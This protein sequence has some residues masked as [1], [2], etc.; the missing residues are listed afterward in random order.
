MGKIAVIG[1]GE[2]WKLFN[3]EDYELSIGV[4]D[5]W[6][7][8]KT[9]IIVCL[10]QPNVFKGDRLNVIN[11]SQ[12][13]IFYSQIVNWD[14]RKDFKKIEL[15]PGYPDRI[16]NLDQKG[17]CKSFCSPFIAVQ[18]AWKLHGATEIHLFGVDLLN[19]PHLDFKICQKIKHH[20]SVLNHALKANNCNL[21]IHGDGILNKLL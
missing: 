7:N 8:V 5:V 12:P 13:K 19:H 3:A 21:I 14:T 15:L 10:D 4:N 11:L 1:L 18:I 6:R 20:F 2:S 16:C 9:D 17:F